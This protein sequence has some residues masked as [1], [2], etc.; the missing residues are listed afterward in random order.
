MAEDEFDTLSWFEVMW[1]LLKTADP[2]FMPY[3]EFLGKIT[4]IREVLSKDNIIE[5]METMSSDNKVT[6]ESKKK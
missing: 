6:I 2:N 4:N 3:R 1:S 5:S